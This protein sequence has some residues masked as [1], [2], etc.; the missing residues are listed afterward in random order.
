MIKRKIKDAILFEQGQYAMAEK[1]ERFTNAANNDTV[2]NKFAKKMMDK[3][4][5]GLERAWQ[6]LKELENEEKS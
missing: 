5:V 1:F 2:T 6:E 3:H 4:R